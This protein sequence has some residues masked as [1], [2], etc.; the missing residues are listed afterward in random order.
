MS[1]TKKDYLLDFMDFQTELSNLAF[2]YSYLG[3]TSVSNA[4]I[5]KATE[6]VALSELPKDYE[7]VK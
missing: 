3:I 5:S 6:L 4:M 1:D 2:K 7:N